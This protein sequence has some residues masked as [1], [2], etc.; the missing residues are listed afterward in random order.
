[1][2]LKKAPV[3]PAKRCCPDIYIGSGEHNA[4]GENG[5]EKRRQ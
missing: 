3:F 4:A 2:T 1:M 5:E